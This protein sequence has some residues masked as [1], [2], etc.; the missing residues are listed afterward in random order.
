MIINGLNELFP[1]NFLCTYI[2]VGP[3]TI[4]ILPGNYFVVLSPAFKENKYIIRYIKKLLLNIGINACLRVAREPL[5]SAPKEKSKQGA[6]RAK[7]PT[8]TKSLILLSFFI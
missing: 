2:D 4:R 5:K 7:N 6:S 8:E 1:I 3:V